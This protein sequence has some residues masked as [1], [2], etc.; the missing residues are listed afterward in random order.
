MWE[1]WVPDR[2]G[3][4][5]N[6][7]LLSRTTSGDARVL[8]ITIG[9]DVLA[10]MGAEKSKAVSI[11]RGRLGQEE[12]L[13]RIVPDPHGATSLA[14]PKSSGKHATISMRCTTV[15]PGP[16][17]RMAPVPKYHVDKTGE[18]VI[19]LPGS[20]L[21]HGAAA[22]PLAAGTEPRAKTAPRP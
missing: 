12:G 7:V 6:G 18:L 3:G 11:F 17:L 1:Q 2:G 16:R 21:G 10:L 22:A 8:N 19:V 20:L 5:R 15:F 13:L 4:R 9:A 14:H